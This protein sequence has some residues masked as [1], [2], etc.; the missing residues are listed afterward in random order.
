M[1]DTGHRQPEGRVEPDKND[2]WQ[3]DTGRGNKEK[4][5]VEKPE[6]GLV[7]ATAG[8]CCQRSVQHYEA[9][10][11]ERKASGRDWPLGRF[12]CVVLQV[13][14]CC[15]CRKHCRFSR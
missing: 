5:R 1:Y 7:E 11:N 8:R 12:R 4:S 10:G 2:C 13:F 9:F 15:Q 3:R 14:H 6:K